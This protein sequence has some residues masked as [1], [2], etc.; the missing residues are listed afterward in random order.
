MAEHEEKEE[1]SLE[2]S[3]SCYDWECLE[4]PSLAKQ[5][6]SCGLCHNLA[7][8]VVELSCEEHEDTEMYGKVSPP[9][10][11]PPPPTTTFEIRGATLL[12]QYTGMPLKIPQRKQQ[13]MSFRIPQKSI[14]RP[15]S[16]YHP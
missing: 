2:M 14:L 1:T 9:P 10:P 13:S 3:S 12:L 8:D 16:N 15:F 6:Y 4:E 5:F 7:K 11:P